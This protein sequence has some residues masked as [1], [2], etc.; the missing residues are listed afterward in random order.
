MLKIELRILAYQ[1]SLSALGKAIERKNTAS[2][3]YKKSIEM[4][5]IKWTPQRKCGW[6]NELISIYSNY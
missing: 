1:F 4:Y 5:K 6:G 2:T 3:F